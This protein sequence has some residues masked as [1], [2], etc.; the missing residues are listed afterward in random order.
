[1]KTKK[2]TS[3]SFLGKFIFL[4]LII[5]VLY[6]K[7]PQSFRKI[8]DTINDVTSTQLENSKRITWRELASGLEVAEAKTKSELSHFTISVFLVRIDPRKFF[9]KVQH[10]KN[11]TT[12]K[13][14][15]SQTGAIGAIN[16]S[17]FDPTGRPLGILIRDGNILQKMPRKGMNTSGVFFMQGNSPGIVHRSQFQTIDVDQAIQSM[18]RL[19]S[20][21]QPVSGINEQ[22]KI[23]RRSAVAIDNRNRVIFA[24][25]D[26]NLSG[27][28][29]QDFQNF[30]SNSH[31]RIKSALNLDGGRSS[32]L[33][34]KYGGYEKSITGL[35]QVPV[36]LA[37]FP[38]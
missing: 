18:P 30:F 33:Y 29:L 8:V 14:I 11:P 3:G 38:K 9:I 19:I 12:A 35:S 5:F 15:V 4:M 6:L 22:G 34:F 10:A 2:S 20:D 36:F 27:L 13:T 1:M 16:G 7:F 26:T 17:F 37:I 24:I 25:T 32:Q 21:F 28:T 31:L 23:K